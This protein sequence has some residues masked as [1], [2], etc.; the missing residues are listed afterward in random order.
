MYQIA[1]PPPIRH[2]RPIPREMRPAQRSHCNQIN[3][4]LADVSLTN[5]IHGGSSDRRKEEEE[6]QIPPL[7]WLNHDGRGGLSKPLAG[8]GVSEDEADQTNWNVWANYR[9][10]LAPSE[11]TGNSASSLPKYWIGASWWNPIIFR[12]RPEIV[13]SPLHEAPHI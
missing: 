5:K 1:Q 6:F 8:R 7:R 13:I 10:L 9:N 2:K 12:N 3:T 11:K 4:S